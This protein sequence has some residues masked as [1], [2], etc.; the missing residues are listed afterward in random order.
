MVVVEFANAPFYTAPGH[1][2]G[3]ARRLQS[4]EASG[5]DFALVGH[6]TLIDGTI[7]PMDAAPI[8]KVYVVTK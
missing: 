1:D 4:A 8:G 3:V 5:A 2:D 6:S 7:I